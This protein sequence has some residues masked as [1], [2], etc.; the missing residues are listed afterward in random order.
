[1]VSPD[2]DTPRR[3]NRAAASQATGEWLA[4]NG[5]LDAEPATVTTAG[6]PRA[7]IGW[8]AAGPGSG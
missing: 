2:P 8:C 5:R 1:M 7:T 3:M 4:M 6:R